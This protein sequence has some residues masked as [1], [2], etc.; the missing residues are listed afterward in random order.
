MGFPAN[1][2]RAVG[3][4]HSRVD[5]AGVW[6]SV[7]AVLLCVRLTHPGCPQ[8]LNCIMD[9]AEKTRRSLTVLRRCQEADR[10]ELNHWI[11]RCSDA[12]EDSKKGP[13]PTARPLSSSTG[14]E[15]AQLGA[16]GGTCG[17]DAG[18]PGARP[19]L[20]MALQ[21]NNTQTTPPGKE[22]SSAALTLPDLRGCP[23]LGSDGTR[24]RHWEAPG[25]LMTVE[26][27]RGHLVPA[28]SQIQ[29]PLPLTVF[30]H[31]IALFPPPPAAETGFP[32]CVPQ[33]PPRSLPRPAPKAQP[34]EA[35]S[36]V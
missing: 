3:R 18:G 1:A 2:S 5:R 29:G 21:G 34:G 8:L 28:P 31:D 20:I 7:L 22:G 26:P 4:L 23:V 11:R 16:L 24:A 33:E 15:G 27:E 19:S 17:A 12:A 9:M 32:P 10:E 6:D 13:G 36:C 35:P 14:T 30:L 25:G